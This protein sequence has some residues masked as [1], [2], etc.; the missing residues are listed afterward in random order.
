MVDA[1]HHTADSL[2]V[3][4]IPHGISFQ[5]TLDRFVFF[6]RQWRYFMAIFFVIALLWERF[7]NT[8]VHRS[9]VSLCNVVQVDLYSLDDVI[10]NNSGIILAI[11]LVRY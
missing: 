7:Q 9:K 8:H 11:I 4:T 2:A 5:R 6:K 1:F 10:D 3:G